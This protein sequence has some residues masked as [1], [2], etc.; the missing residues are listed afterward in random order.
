M[1]GVG[2]GVRRMS[3]V[4]AALLLVSAAVSA[5]SPARVSTEFGSR[6]GAVPRE[7]VWNAETREA[8]TAPEN[9][10]GH[11]AAYSMLPAPAAAGVLR[12]GLEGDGSSFPADR[13]GLRMMEEPRTGTFAWQFRYPM[14]LAAVSALRCY[15]VT[16]P[17]SGRIWEVS[18][19]LI[20]MPIGPP[21]DGISVLAGC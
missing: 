16:R 15:C 7:P 14:L 10:R 21:R 12:Q 13:A 18:T 19:R 4:V 20:L 6:R 9:V 5:I 1:A 3:Q 17:E 2:I 8:A 11:Q